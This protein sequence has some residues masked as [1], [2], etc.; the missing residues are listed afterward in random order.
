MSLK[1]LKFHY[2]YS[3]GGFIKT[4]QKVS[5]L[6]LNIT[7]LSYLGELITVQIDLGDVSELEADLLEVF[8]ESQTIG[9][10]VNNT[11]VIQHSHLTN[12]AE[13]FDK[14]IEVIVDGNVIESVT[15]LISIELKDGEFIETS[16]QVDYSSHPPKILATADSSLYFVLAR[17]LQMRW[18][19]ARNRYLH[20]G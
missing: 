13:T 8:N 5:N 16:V 7:L 15:A 11:I 6:L 2:H 20:S 17:T 14:L 1:F 9:F 3:V 12:Y 4:K 19:M 10:F 18:T